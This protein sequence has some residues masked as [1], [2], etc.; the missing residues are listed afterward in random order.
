MMQINRNL[1]TGCDG[2]ALQRQQRVF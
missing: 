1:S 2:M